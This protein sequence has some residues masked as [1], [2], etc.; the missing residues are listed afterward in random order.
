LQVLYAPLPGSVL[1]ATG[2]PAAK[3]WIAGARSAANACIVD[4]GG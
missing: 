4:R 1:S 3:N 2:D